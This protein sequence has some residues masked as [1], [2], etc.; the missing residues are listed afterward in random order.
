MVVGVEACRCPH[1]QS[2]VGLGNRIDGSLHF[3]AVGVGAGVD[4][5]AGDG[6]VVDECFGGEVLPV[7]GE[8]GIISQIDLEV[9][10]FLTL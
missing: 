10:E 9:W 6:L 2:I 1:I 5:D 4:E 8:D 3:Q 7:G